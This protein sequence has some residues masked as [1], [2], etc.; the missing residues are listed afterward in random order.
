VVFPDG[1]PTCTV[2][3][4]PILLGTD[5]NYAILA[6]SGITTVPVS[7]ITGNIAVSPIAEAAMTG[8]SF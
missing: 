2:P 7:V 3:T 1:I 6:K 8:F 4:A 5:S